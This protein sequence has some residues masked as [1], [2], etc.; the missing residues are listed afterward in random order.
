MRRRVLLTGIILL[1]IAAFV[2]LAVSLARNSS[3][4][5]SGKGLQDGE[6]TVETELPNAKCKKVVRLAWPPVRLECKEK[7]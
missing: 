4:S 1:A 6:A 5:L 2:T 3:F 7:E